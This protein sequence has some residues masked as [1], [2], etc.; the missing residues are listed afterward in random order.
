MGG[1][2]AYACAHLLPLVGQRPT[3]A[4]RTWLDLV[5]EYLAAQRAGGHAPQ[6]N[7]AESGD[8]VEA[9]IGRFGG[10]VLGRCLVD[11][12]VK[13]RADRALQSGVDH[14]DALG[15]ADRDELIVG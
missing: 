8:G 13:G 5:K 2:V 14:R 12:E 3:R 7:E 10:I 4:L 1:S 15:G 11:A 6:S 9:R